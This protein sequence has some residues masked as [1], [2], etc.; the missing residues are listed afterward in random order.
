MSRHTFAAT[1]ASV[2]LASTAFAQDAP[3]PTVTTTTPTVAV[4][5][6]AGL[7]Y[8][9]LNLEERAGEEPLPIKRVL[10]FW[11]G[12]FVRRNVGDRFGIQVEALIGQRGAEDDDNPPDGRFRLL[13]L[14]VPVTARL[15]ATTSSGAGFYVF[16]GP[17]FSVNLKAEELAYEGGT[18]SISDEIRGWDFGW[19]VGVGA[20]VRRF[21]LDARYTHGIL[22]INKTSGGSVRNSAFN[23]LFG[24]TLF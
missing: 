19:T 11:G 21:S 4:G 17:Q 5:L 2:L 22:D 13:Y 7:S 15:G 6:K 3:Q 16:T 18:R 1:I 14:D 23:V 12:A 8:S 24:V 20:D 9:T 10:D